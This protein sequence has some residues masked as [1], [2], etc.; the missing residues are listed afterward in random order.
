M[1]FWRGF[2]IVP[3]TRFSGLFFR[4]EKPR[5]DVM[6]QGATPVNRAAPC[7]VFLS[8]DLTFES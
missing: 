3:K 8:E 2:D 7:V 1:A 5:R 4:Y 6:E